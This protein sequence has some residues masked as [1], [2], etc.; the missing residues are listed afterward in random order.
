MSPISLFEIANVAFLGL[1]AL[2]ASAA[3]GAGVSGLF[4]MGSS[5]LQSLQARS[6]LARTIKARKAM[7]KLEFQRNKKMWKMMAAYNAPV[8]QMQRFEEAGLNP[9][10]IYGQGTPGNV[11]SYPTYNA[12]QIPMAQIPAVDP[13]GAAGDAISDYFGFN[14][15]DAQAGKIRATEENIQKMTVGQATKNLI[16]ELNVQSAK[17]DALKARAARGGI[18]DEQGFTITEYGSYGPDFRDA[19]VKNV[20]AQLKKPQLQN[21][22]QKWTNQFQKVKARMAT[23]QGISLTDSGYLR[24]IMAGIEMIGDILGFDP[25]ISLNPN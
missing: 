19:S 15:Q 14:V 9:N 24:A 4:G 17:L 6:N 10:L 21:I 5:F 1:G 11:G 12:P 13:F 16:L 18:S 20:F 7:A 2:A 23:E 22:Y 8:M 25:N 3:L